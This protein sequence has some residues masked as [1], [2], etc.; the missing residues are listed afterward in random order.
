MSRTWMASHA[1]SDGSGDRGAPSCCPASVARPCPM[2]NQPWLAAVIAGV[3]SLVVAIVT[4]YVTTTQGRLGRNIQRE[5]AKQQERAQES[6]EAKRIAA[7]TSITNFQ[8]Q[9]QRDLEAFKN[10]LQV[11]GQ[12]ADRRRTQEEERNRYW[13]PLRE[14]ADDLKHRI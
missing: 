1:F 6:L 14:A 11:T 4:A 5:L 10:T 12:E 7:Q 13:T 8:I 9:A 2:G 3:V